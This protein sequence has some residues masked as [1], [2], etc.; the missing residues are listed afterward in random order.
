METRDLA[1]IN[2]AKYTNDQC[3]RFICFQAL[4]RKTYQL[5][6]VMITFFIISLTSEPNRKRKLGSEP[7]RA[8]LYVY[9]KVECEHGSG[10]RKRIGYSASIRVFSFGYPNRAH[11]YLSI[12]YRTPIPFP[13]RDSMQRCAFRITG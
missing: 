4:I 2:N 7:I 6:K 11:L 5:F 1:G 3:H 10:N 8:V 12:T 9:A 13:Q